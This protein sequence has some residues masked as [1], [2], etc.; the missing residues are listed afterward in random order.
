MELWYLRHTP[1]CLP[2]PKVKKVLKEDSGHPEC[3]IED[4]AA[5]PNAFEKQQI[6]VYDNHQSVV[7]SFGVISEVLLK[8]I[9][10]IQSE[11]SLVKEHLDMQDMMFQLIL[12]RLP[13][14]PPYNPYPFSK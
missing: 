14:P 2:A 3:V 12:S 9:A 13:P 1:L 5:H 6:V 8:T 10:D 4:V 11:S 7:T